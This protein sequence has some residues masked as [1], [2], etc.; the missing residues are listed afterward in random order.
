MKNGT[1]A[2]REAGA[3]LSLAVV[4]ATTAWVARTPRL[5]LRADGAVYRLDL[6]FPAITVAGALKL[7]REGDHLF[8]DTRDVDA[9]ATARVPGAF[10]VRQDSF[11][12]D[13]RAVRDFLGPADCIVLYGDNLLAA[14]AVASRL[15]E[16]GYT[17][18]TLMRG[19]LAAWRS[20]GGP[21]AHAE[22]IDD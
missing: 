13:L 22:D 9:D 10:S 8:V 15:K 20:A 17:D 16:R 19:D 3:L 1:R 5:P 18:L 4:L 21:V 14:S 2:C 11:A 6:Q 7:Y 12:D